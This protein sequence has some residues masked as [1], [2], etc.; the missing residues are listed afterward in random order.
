MKFHADEKI[1]DILKS[2]HFHAYI[3]VSNLDQA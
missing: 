2:L 3:I 1:F